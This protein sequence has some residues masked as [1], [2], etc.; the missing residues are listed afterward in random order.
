MHVPEIPHKAVLFVINKNYPTA[1]SLGKA[2]PVYEAVRF[3]WRAKKSRLEDADY[4]LAVYHKKIIGAFVADDWTDVSKA[5]TPPNRR[6]YAFVG[7]EAPLCM[8]KDL[9]VE[10]SVPDSLLRRWSRNPVK[11]ANC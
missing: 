7:R 2:D 6:R 10:K 9:Y 4:V 8:H 1:V 11:Y 3:A 5:G